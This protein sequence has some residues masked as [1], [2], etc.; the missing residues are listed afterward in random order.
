MT[1]YF[2]ANYHPPTPSDYKRYR[3]RLSHN[4]TLG[5]P[6]WLL[7]MVNKIIENGLKRKLKAVLLKS[8]GKII[9][10]MQAKW[11]FQQPTGERER[12]PCLLS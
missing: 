7:S 3:N 10:L 5:F 8:E 4:M 2:Y 12:K 6:L 9:A 1:Y 11:K